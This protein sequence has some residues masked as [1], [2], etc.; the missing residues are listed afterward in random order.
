MNDPKFNQEDTLTAQNRANDFL[1]RLA[2]KNKKAKITG[3]DHQLVTFQPHCELISGRST[4]LQHQRQHVAYSRPVKEVVQ[5]Y[6]N[7]RKMGWI[8][9]HTAHLLQWFLG[10]W[11][12]SQVNTNEFLG[13]NCG[14]LQ[15]KLILRHIETHFHLADYSFL[16][17]DGNLRGRRWNIYIKKPNPKHM[18]LGVSGVRDGG[19][20]WRASRY[21]QKADYATVRDSTKTNLCLY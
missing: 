14:T 15:A 1:S 13:S 3:A 5:R 6:L 19:Y 21:L 8:I 12:E 20:S 18:S 9:S 2:N 10:G 16:G 11:G 17:W 4:R 7:P